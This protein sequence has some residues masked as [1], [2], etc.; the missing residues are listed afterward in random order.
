M[1]SNRLGLD[2][3]EIDSLWVGGPEDSVEMPSLTLNGLLQRWFA[4]DQQVASVA[5]RVFAY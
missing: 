5:R 1:R 4:I 3:S 2:L